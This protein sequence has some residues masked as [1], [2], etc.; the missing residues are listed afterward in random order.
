[1][2]GEGANW[3][4]EAPFS[5]RGH[6]FQN[7]GDGTYNHSGTLAI[8]WAVAA[9]TNITYKI[10][11][12]DAVAMTGGQQIEGGLTVDRIA[13]QCAAE[14]V[15]AIAVVADDPKKYPKHMR[16]P[17][18]TT[19]DSRETLDAV[20][21]RL[22]AVPGVTILIYDQACAS[23]KRHRRKKGLVPEPDVRVVINEAVCEGCGDCGAA[24][25]CVSVQPVETE[26]G[27]KRTID[28]TACNR[29]LT[30]VSGFCPAIVTVTGATPRKAAPAALDG[31]VPLPP[32]QTPAQLGT[33][34]YAIIL[35]GTGGTGV[36][37]LGAILGMAA[38]LEGKGCGILDMAGLAQKGGVVLTH[39]K[40]AEQPADINAIR[41]AALE[42][43]LVLGC[44][45]VAAA[46]RKVI[47]AMRT[48]ETALVVNSAALY[49]GEITRKPDFD[50]PSARL[51]KQLAA[52]AGASARFVDAT[53]AATT[54]L[55][56][57]LAANMFMLGYAWQSGLVPLGEAAILRAITLN[58]EAVAMNRSA[59]A[60]GRRAAAFPD[61]IAAMTAAALPTARRAAPARTLDEIVTRRARYLAA[62][63]D[64]AYAERYRALVERAQAAEQTHAPGTTRLAEAVAKGYFKL[65]AIKD[66][67]EV[68][69]LYADGTFARQMGEAFEGDVSVTYH[70]APPVLGRRG[71]DG[72]PS[73]TKFGPWM[74]RVFP[75]I[76]KGKRL[77]GTPL[78]PFGR[79]A[80]RRM[81]RELVAEYEALM[82]EL[83]A[84]LAPE[85]LGTAV[86][87]AALPEKIRGFGHVKEKN[88]VTAKAEEAKL[89]ATWR[90]TSPVR[91]AAE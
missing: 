67:Y 13:A 8:R 54:L 48:D 38:H 73:K 18:G 70:L 68:A 16:W 77:R 79:S 89:L 59:F 46:S 4:G 72:L 5:T 40:L 28:Q 64:D 86:A 58:G 50:L 88:R 76:A 51:E 43:D 39:V 17:A 80:E 14:G 44:D 6:V 74:A 83:F 37:T 34:P 12:N 90:A 55:G 20:Q 53:R 35:A 24:S 26:F 33:K 85:N 65:L 3:I 30:C 10:L 42:A 71:A 23:Q 21:R 60:L 49:P 29:D 91:L 32:R 82:D 36:V 66:E 19:V 57:S 1:M 56:T 63:Q 27:R 41:V 25:N 45:L 87:L 81:E 7:L 62:Y 75:L 61:E 31:L 15:A 69:R 9:K 11:F 22:A 84:N 52:A 78:D 47:G 2:G